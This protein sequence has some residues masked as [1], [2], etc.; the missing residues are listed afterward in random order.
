M[1]RTDFCS[2]VKGL[3]GELSFDFH[4]RRSLEDSESTRLMSATS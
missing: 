4:V 3:V 2:D 1:L